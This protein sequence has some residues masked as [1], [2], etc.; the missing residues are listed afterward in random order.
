[1]Y[2]YYIMYSK[3]TDPQTGKKISADSKLGKQIL[4]NYLTILEGGGAKQWFLNLFKGAPAAATAPKTD[5]VT[6]KSFDNDSD[7]DSDDEVY[8]V[9]IHDFLGKGDGEMR[10]VDKGTLV[11]YTPDENP[12]GWVNAKRVYK[13]KVL[14]KGFIPKAF[15]KDLFVPPLSED[16]PDES[17]SEDIFEPPPIIDRATSA[18]YSSPHGDD[19][20]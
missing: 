12:D 1:M 17:S 2:Y 9:M 13:L 6:I 10:R 14:E 7:S 4:T 15:I 5:E 11:L 16:R 8:G 20:W 3:I 18:D 19:D